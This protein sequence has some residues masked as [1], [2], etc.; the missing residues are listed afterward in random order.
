MKNLDI[1]PMRIR[2]IPEI[3]EIER[4]VFSFSLYTEN[5]SSLDIDGTPLPTQSMSFSAS[6][7]MKSR[8]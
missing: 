1:R 4:Q 3:L 8:R 2:D 5:S 7:G 6:G